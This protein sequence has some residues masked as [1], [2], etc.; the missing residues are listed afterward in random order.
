M[1]EHFWLGMTIVFFSG[2][3]NGCFPLPMK[4]SRKWRW[5]NT[6]LLF[7]LVSTIILPAV[8][9][10]LFV[11][12][13]RQVYH[14]VAWRALLPPLV[15]G[16]LW[17]TAQVT[18]GLSFKAVGVALGFA[19]IAGMNAFFGSLIPL[20][21]LHPGDVL[22]PRG[23]V[24]LLSMPILFLGLWLYAQAGRKREKEQLAPDSAAGEPKASFAKGLALCIY[25]GLIGG[26]INLGFAFGGD[27]VAK[28][29]SLGGNAVTST[30]AVWFLVL[31]AG[32]L[33]SAV[34]CPYLLSRNHGWGLFTQTGA[35]R[36][37]LLAISMAL[38]WVIAIFSYG[39]GATSAG[40]YGIAICYTLLVAM[41]I[42][43]STGVGLLTGEW[44]GT[45]GGTR[46]TL[47]WAMAVVLASVIILNLGGLF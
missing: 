26:S 15:F 32:F 16:F 18:I 12:N 29:L 28:S 19:V 25:T 41:T 47:F 36:E 46:K 11:P 35:A 10:S 44:K 27:V 13:L 21:V 23:L 31:C 2:I 14:E 45:S 17:G 9:V 39:V 43:A 4:Y 24:L 3:F 33:P 34:Y 38:L 20:L 8:I 30:Y 5:E 22:R 7:A 40:K 1:T 42:V 6:W 37:A